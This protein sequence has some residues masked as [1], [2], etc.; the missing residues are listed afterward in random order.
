M[1]GPR[2]LHEGTYLYPKNPRYEPRVLPYL[3]VPKPGDKPR[4]LHDCWYEGTNHGYRV[5]DDLS[6]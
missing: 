3:P 6:A 4:V 1:P 5:L 2:I